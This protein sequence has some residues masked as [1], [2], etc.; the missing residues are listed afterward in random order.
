MF[1]FE[2]PEYLRLLWAVPALLLLLAAWWRWRRKALAQLAGPGAAEQMVPGFSGGRFWIKNL[3]FLGALILLAFAW[4]NPQ[5][6]AKQQTAVQ[7]SADVIIA[8]DISQ[9]MLAEDVRPSR[10]VLARIF[11]QKLVQAL[12]GERI[13]LIFFAG[14]AY[15]Q[16]PLSTDY[17]A[18]MSFLTEASPDLMT[19]QGTALPAA[20]RLAEQTFDPETPAGRALVLITDGEDHD[21]DAVSAAEDARGNGALI[22]TVGAGTAAGGPIPWSPGGAAGYNRDDKGELVRTRLNETL[23]HD[24]AR[25]GGGQAYHISQGDAAIDAIHNA[26]NQLRKREVAVRSYTEFESY[27]QWLLLPAFLLLLLETWIFWKKN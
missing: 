23:L 10:L 4:A 11:A 14:D 3:L 21:A 20:I 9:S 15:V 6:G 19:A 8:L 13:G 25:A 5:R 17:G 18:A 7:Q 1:R 16:M 24:V 2:H 12:A 27:F 26:V 22:F